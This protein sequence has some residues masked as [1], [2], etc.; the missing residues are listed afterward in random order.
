MYF[1][2]LLPAH[3]TEAKVFLLEKCVRSAEMMKIGNEV[4]RRSRWELKTEVQRSGKS[5]RAED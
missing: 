5:A 4:G 2:V 1:E 3:V